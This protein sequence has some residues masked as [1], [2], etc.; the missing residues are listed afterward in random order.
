MGACHHAPYDSSQAGA[1]NLSTPQLPTANSYSLNCHVQV[2]P[3][4]YLGGEQAAAKLCAAG[5]FEPSDFKMIAGC[6]DCA[7][8]S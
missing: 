7:M 1:A 2:C 4:I 5:T 6:A 8:V 3:G